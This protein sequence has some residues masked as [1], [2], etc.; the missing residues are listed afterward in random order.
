MREPKSLVLP[1]HH[2]VVG[3]IPTIFPPTGIFAASL[4]LATIRIFFDPIPARGFGKRRKR[5]AAT[6]GRLLLR[7]SHALHLSPVP[8]SPGYLRQLGNVKKAQSFGPS[9]EQTLPRAGAR[10]RNVARSSRKNRHRRPLC[11]RRR[12]RHPSFSHQSARCHIGINQCGTC[13]LP[14]LLPS[15][16]CFPCG[17]ISSRRRILDDSNCYVGIVDLRR[18][19]WSLLNGL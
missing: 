8:D 2:R 10:R 1:L 15:F 18:L 19:R 4:E 9:P 6:V 12:Q 14:I 17:C 13:V 16:P 3:W 7:R 11:V 5:V